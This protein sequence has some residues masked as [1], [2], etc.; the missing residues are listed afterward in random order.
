MWT[1]SAQNGVLSTI[2]RY[3]C[4]CAEGHASGLAVARPAVSCVATKLTAAE[5]PSGSAPGALLTAPDTPSAGVSM[6]STTASTMACGAIV[7]HLRES[8]H[9]AC[10]QSAV[11]H[12]FT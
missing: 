3:Q 10:G 9:Y 11:E 8:W 5:D 12:V 6:R 2:P 7:V 4:R 1:A